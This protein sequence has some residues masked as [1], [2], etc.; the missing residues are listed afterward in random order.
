MISIVVL[1]ALVTIA[2]PQ[3]ANYKKQ[4]LIAQAIADIRTIDLAIRTYRAQNN[5]LP[6][7]LAAVP[8]GNPPDPWGRPYVYLDISDVSGKPRRDRH[9]RPIN[10]D[11]DLYSI[12]EDGETHDD[13][14]HNRSWDDIVRANDGGYVG[15][16]S[17]Y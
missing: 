13:L 2:I 9:L 1:S 4:A 7:S 15:L 10:S 8:N 12:G 17:D 6:P 11:F 3:F 14:D 5:A 16:A